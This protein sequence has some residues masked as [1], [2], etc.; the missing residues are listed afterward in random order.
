MLRRFRTRRRRR[1]R[2]GGVPVE[3]RCRREDL[4]IFYM[5]DE[6]GGIFGG[7]KMQRLSLA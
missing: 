5:A 2:G 4:M 7:R 1:R 6:I 3:S